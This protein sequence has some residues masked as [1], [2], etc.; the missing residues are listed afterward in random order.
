MGIHHSHSITPFNRF[1][2]LFDSG[3]GEM[4]FDLRPSDLRRHTLTWMCFSE[5]PKWC[6][7]C[8]CGMDGGWEWNEC[9]YMDGNGMSVCIWCGCNVLLVCMYGCTGL[10]ICVVDL[11]ERAIFWKMEVRW[12]GWIFN[13]V[14]MAKSQFK[15][16]FLSYWLPVTLGVKNGS[17]EDRVRMLCEQF[18]LLCEFVVDLVFDL[19]LCK[20]ENN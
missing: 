11:N 16:E 4:T 1:I 19:C 6:C 14:G 7:C 12:V 13:P 5:N 9:I 3:D 2:Y 10:R 17:C 8:W 18:E 15:L 20:K